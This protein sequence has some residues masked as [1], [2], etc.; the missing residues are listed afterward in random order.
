MGRGILAAEPRR[1]E[2][3]GKRVGE[4]P[5]WKRREG[6]NLTYE[7]A[8]AIKSA[9]AL[10]CFQHLSMLSYQD[11]RDRGNQ[12]KNAENILKVKEISCNNQITRLIDG[13]A[14]GEFDGNFKDGLGLAEQYGVLDHYQVLDSGVLIAL[15]GVWYHSSEKVHCEPCLPLTKNGKT[16]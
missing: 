12:R 3:T 11:S 8:D 14:P 13:I 10:F 2:E 7:F 15:D 9:F 5:E 16:T 4:N 6:F 1:F